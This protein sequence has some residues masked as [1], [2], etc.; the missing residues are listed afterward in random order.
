MKTFKLTK[1]TTH[2]LACTLL[3]ALAITTVSCSKEEPNAPEETERR[4]TA[5]AI[6]PENEPMTRLIYPTADQPQWANDDVFGVWR[7]GS[8]SVSEFKRTN[9]NG[10]STSANFEGTITCKDNDQFYA[11][12]PK[13]AGARDNETETFIFIKQGTSL[14]ENAHLHCVYATSKLES[15]GTTINFGFKHAVAMMKIKFEGTGTPKSFKLSATS[16]ITV[17]GTLK[18]TSKGVE[19]GWSQQSSFLNVEGAFA[20]KT[21]YIFL[22]PYD[23][24]KGVNLEI[25]DTNNKVTTVALSDQLVVPGTIYEVTVPFNPAP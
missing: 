4:I 15:D 2:L 17:Q 11:F 7:E 14:Q 16:F 20:D 24:L 22:Y 1:Q 3:C 13:Q 5:T 8:E 9:L 6:F 23:D 25:T 10:P 19:P 18:I 12:Y 21:A